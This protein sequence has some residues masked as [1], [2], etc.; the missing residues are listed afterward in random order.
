LK[1]TKATAA[2]KKGLSRPAML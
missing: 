1:L 2:S